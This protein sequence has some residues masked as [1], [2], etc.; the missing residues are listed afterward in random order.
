M[1]V[2]NAERQCKKE[3][4]N[5]AAVIATCAKI[6][7]Q[8]KAVQYFL[9][10]SPGLQTQAQ[11]IL[12]KLQTCYM[13][14]KPSRWSIALQ[15]ISQA[16]NFARGICRSIP[17]SSRVVH[18][19]PTLA[20]AI[21]RN[22]P[23]TPRAIKLIATGALLGA[24][25]SKWAGFDLNSY[26][27]YLA[28]AVGAYAV[29]RLFDPRAPQIV[30]KTV[31]GTLYNKGKLKE[32]RTSQETQASCLLGSFFYY[33]F[34]SEMT[35]ERI[36]ATQKQTDSGTTIELDDKEDEIPRSRESFLRVFEELE[37]EVTEESPLGFVINNKEK[38][39]AISIG[40]DKK[41]R[42]PFAVFDPKT[43][44]CFYFVRLKN[45]ANKAYEL[46]KGG[47]GLFK[48]GK[49]NPEDDASQEYVP[50]SER[51][52]IGSRIQS[53]G[54]HLYFNFV[55]ELRHVSATTNR[56]YTFEEIRDLFTKAC[57]YFANART[58]KPISIKDLLQVF[59][60]G[61]VKIDEDDDEALKFFAKFYALDAGDM[62]G[63]LDVLFRDKRERLQ[64][65]RELVTPS[66]RYTKEEMDGWLQG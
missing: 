52:K 14:L 1:A 54:S 16:G 50:R 35:P 9:I 25:V 47:T 57:T 11:T 64:R 8:H 30:D 24:S 45:A 38:N 58:K 44:S 56:Q 41:G 28:A 49:C 62:R 65:F 66:K 20:S 12:R 26:P 43:S 5:R 13:H 34:D 22:R 31:Q 39:H 32:L 59:Y 40:I 19:I 21:W 61:N 33:N 51:I 63:Q 48:K 17:C 18:L 23:R 29:Y 2:D 3:S 42:Y 46:T 10:N 7:N 4:F 27:S 37:S 36:D 60:K 6:N 55:Q 53:V 15:R